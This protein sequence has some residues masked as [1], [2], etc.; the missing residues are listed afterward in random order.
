M[1]KFTT[2]KL[3]EN[4][5]KILDEVLETGQPIAVERKGQ[6]I[7][8]N[9]PEKKSKLANLVKRK[10]LNVNPDD[11]INNDWVKSWKPFL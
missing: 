3:R 9:P 6:L 8:I 7:M 5:Y 10:G 11:I 4:L 2:T 1:T